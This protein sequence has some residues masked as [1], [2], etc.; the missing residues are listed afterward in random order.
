MEKKALSMAARTVVTRFTCASTF[1]SLLASSSSFFSLCFA[2]LIFQCFLAVRV[3]FPVGR[4]REVPL[5]RVWPCWFEG[6]MSREWR[7][8]QVWCLWRCEMRRAG[9]MSRGEKG[10]VMRCMGV[11]I[12][13][14]RGR[15]RLRDGGASKENMR[16]FPVKGSRGWKVQSVYTLG[17]FWVSE[18]HERGRE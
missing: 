15:G 13:A 7:R 14:K 12:E 5:R 10:A 9:C 16:F 3:M 4:Y 2:C 18:I 8:L 1:C 17:A 11:H 6:R